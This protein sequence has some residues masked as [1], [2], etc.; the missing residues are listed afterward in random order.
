M[1]VN[2]NIF[3]K[4][5]G[6]MVLPIMLS[7]V[8]AIAQNES[9]FSLK[10]QF[11]PRFELR[12]GNFRPLNE[13]EK[14]AALISERIRLSMD[15][16]YKNI[17][18]VKI[19]PQSVG[20]WGQANMVQGAE[21]SGN[22]LSL[23]EAWAKLRL[24]DNWNL[25]TGRQVISLDDERFFGELDWAQ[26]GRAHDAVSI[27]YNKNNYELKGFFAFNQ[28]YRSVYGNNLNNPSGNYYN[29]TDALPYKWMQTLWAGIPIDKYSKIT[30]IATNLGLQNISSPTSDT[31]V[32][33]SQTIGAN[34]FYKDSKISGQLA[35]Y[36]Q[37][38]PIPLKSTNNAFMFAANLDYKVNEN[39]KIGIGS[40]Y[41]TGNDINQ[42]IPNTKNN[43]FNPYFHTGHKF[44]G[45]MD[46]F[47]AGN[48]HRGV[49][50][51]DNYLKVVY[52]SDRAYSINAV[53]HQFFT[54]NSINVL[55]TIGE[56]SK[57]LGQEL[58]LSFSTKLNNF[59][60]LT[61]GYSFFLN[62]ETLNYLK[63][64]FTTDSYQQWLWISLNVNPTLFKIK[65]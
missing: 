41:L 42:T 48:G 46:Y 3:Y 43:A 49:G 19:A 7:S 64:T 17:L 26:G 25:K 63:S 40:D 59:A 5:I 16:S 33:F 35:A 27:H 38:N 13:N 39:W 6:A 15:Y 54:P 44:Y 56:Y 36:F 55:S 4:I 34:Y 21:N 20:V 37:N 24:N 52:N 22:Q 61:G 60:S 51:S 10:A 47:Y 65:N 53:F 58:D 62:T 30:V 32:R 18:E 50:L 28:N 1:Q 2:S 11:R 29:T 57:N 8:D 12:D 9:D 14:P 45:N 31:V 23:F